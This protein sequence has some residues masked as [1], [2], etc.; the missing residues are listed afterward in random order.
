VEAVWAARDEMAMTTED[1]LA[2]RTRA[3]LR[4]AGAAA[5]SAPAVAHLLAPEWGCDPADAAREA[6]AVG[7]RIRRDLAR[8]GLDSVRTAP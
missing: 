3:V 6:A 5:E 1:V 4:R 7:D 8:A 2:R